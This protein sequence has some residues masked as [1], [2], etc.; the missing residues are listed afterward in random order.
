MII[1][2][3]NGRCYSEPPKPVTRKRTGFL[4]PVHSTVRKRTYIHTL[5]MLTS[6]YTAG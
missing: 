3:A 6:E 2:P 4:V 5:E 1:I